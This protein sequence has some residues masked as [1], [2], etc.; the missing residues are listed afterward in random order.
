VEEEDGKVIW[1]GGPARSSSVGAHQNIW[2]WGLCVYSAFVL[3]MFESHITS[4]LRR[5]QGWALFALVLLAAR[6][7]AAEPWT[8]TYGGCIFSGSGHAC[9]RGLLPYSKRHPRSE[10]EGITELPAVVFL[11]FSQLSELYVDNNQLAK[12]L[13]GT[14]SDLSHL[15]KLSLFNNWLRSLPAGHFS[16]LLQFPELR[17]AS[18]SAQM[19]T[20]HRGEEKGRRVG[21]EMIFSVGSMGLLTNGRGMGTVGR[22]KGPVWREGGGKRRRR[23]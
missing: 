18:L 22:R 16:D 19:T 6:D 15:T 9:A 8:R 5:S 3:S 14:F 20:A 11:G 12:L 7:S 4:M 23:G 17:L 21:I 1:E 2:G 10:P 13:A